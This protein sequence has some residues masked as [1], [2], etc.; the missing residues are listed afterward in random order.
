MR[1]FAVADGETQEALL[2]MVREGHLGVLATIA[3]D[4]RPHLSNVI[5]AYDPATRIIRVSVTQGRIKTRN[6]LRDPRATMHVS[7][8][9]GWSWAA[10]EGT[11]ELSPVAA[12]PNDDTVDE[13]VAL[14]RTIQGEHPDWD[15]YRQ[16][17]VTDQRLVVRLRVERAYGM[18]SPTR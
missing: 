5:Y 9:G 10:A 18:M 7:A 16:A 15:D 12:D 1:R 11:A 8:G 6:L 13:L 4:G 3:S 14:Y 17:M 2:E